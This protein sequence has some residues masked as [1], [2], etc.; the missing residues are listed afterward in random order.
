MKKLLFIA[1]SVI[2]TC[3]H[4]LAQSDKPLTIRAAV[5]DGWT[6]EALENA[7]AFM[8]SNNNNDTIH[9]TKS[10]LWSGRSR[11]DMVKYVYVNFNI[12]KQPGSYIIKAFAEGY[13]TVYTTV[14]IDKIGARENLKEIPELEFYRKSKNLGAATVTATKVKFYMSGDTIV[15]NA[16][17][18]KLPEGSMLDALIKQMPGVEM[19]DDGEIFVNGK[20]VESLLLNGKDFFKG[21]KLVMLN[22]LGAYTVNKVKV[23]DKL[24]E[25]SKFAGVD[26]GDSEYVMDVNLKK[27]YMN[28]YIGNVEVG[29]GT[30]DRYMARLFGMWYTTRSRV[31][32][33]GSL[34]NL[35][36]NR[37]PGQNT[38][39][40]ATT[41]PGD[42]RT[43]MAGVEYNLNGSDNKW[44]VFGDATVQHTRSFTRADTYTTSFH[45]DRRTY[46][47][48]FANALSHNLDVKTR[49][50]LMLRPENKFYYASAFLN[51]NNTDRSSKT[52]SGTFNSA[53]EQLTQ[54]LLEQIFNGSLSSFAD[55][56]I[57][58]SLTQTLT[59]GHTLESGGRISSE[60]KIPHSPDLISVE[61]SGK[62]KRQRH[63]DYNLYD[64]NYNAAGNRATNYQFINNSPDRSWTFTAGTKYTYVISEFTSID[65]KPYWVHTST[66]KNSYL[67]Q[68]DRLE[69]IGIFGQLPD[70]YKSSLNHDQTY[71]SRQT[72]DQAEI[73]L[74]AFNIIKLDNDRKFTY[75]INA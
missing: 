11:D 71:M 36:D 35:N 29:A 31:T 49:H 27:E 13:D 4:A 54:A 64:I 7:K 58:T 22:N 52:L 75:Q 43:K 65:I 61:A 45:P 53:T 62:Y 63:G 60:F 34:N 55:N 40:S 59:S 33:L 2:A 74:H 46:G 14:D 48:S 56:P 9:S 73:Y 26:L 16:D 5:V 17:A 70:N 51:Y 10:S 42:T 68:L 15:Y 24:S 19:N 44:E 47:T 67:Y 18:F 20:K 28:G 41:T 1:I 3:S 57:Y 12:P 21:N 66:T 72:D 30:A 37:T 69:D 23:Y 50:T 6:G 38:A 25:W 32:V 8:L 39:W